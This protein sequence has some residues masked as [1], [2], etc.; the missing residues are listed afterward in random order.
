MSAVTDS[1]IKLFVGKWTIN[2]VTVDVVP[3]TN[4]DVILM[5]TILVHLVFLQHISVSSFDRM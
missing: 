2:V 4:I 3:M 1:S 5:I